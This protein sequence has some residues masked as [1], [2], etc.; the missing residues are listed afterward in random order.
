MKTIK[1]FKWRLSIPFLLMALLIVSC[2]KKEDIRE[3][4]DVKIEGVKINNELFTPVYTGNVAQIVI[5]GGRDLSKVKL[6]LLIVNGEAVNFENNETYDCRKPISVSLEGSN[7]R[8]VDVVLKIQSPPAL[9]TFIIEGMSIP[10]EDI[11]FSAR[12]LI[13]QVPETTDLTALKVSM[14]FLNGTVLDFT[15]GISIDYSTPKTFK[16]KGI[17][18]ETI[19]TYDLIVTSEQIG[20]ASVKAMTINGV[21]TDSV[22]LV[23]PSTLVP[24]VKGLTNFAKA[25]VTLEVGFGNTLDPAFTGTGLDLL[26]GTSKVKVTGSDGI[27]KE[28]SIG[29]PQLSLLPVFSK[30]YASFG[31][32]ANDLVGTAFSGTHI[33]VSNYSAVAPT[34]IG[35]NYYNL[36]GQFEGTLNKANVTIAHSLRKLASDDNGAFLVVPLGLTD[37][38]VTTYKWNNVTAVADPYIKYSKASLG[39]SYQPRSAGINISGSLSGNAII[40]IGMAQQADVFIWTVTGGVLNPVPQKLTIPYVGSYYWGIEPLPV[41]TQG[42]V[43]AVVGSSFTGILSM[44]NT[45]SELS[46]QSGLI[47][48]DCKVINRNGRL[49]LAYIAFSS[50]KGA[51]MRI[52]DITDGQADSYKNPI[53]NVLMVSTAANVNNTM[54]VD[55]AVI[56]GKLH[57]VFACTNLGMQLYKLEY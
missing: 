5:P 12:S 4:Q 3:Y 6:Q 10:K 36:S 37:A 8:Q 33:V 27:Q 24:Y 16:I 23:A 28:F 50:G 53:F 48:T 2:K 51:Y 49:Y 20:P 42:Y 25:N 45:M 29:R 14:E 9:S 52:C 22:V 18:E 7:G 40:T 46:K 44:N 30:A 19:Y 35:P 1:Y 17:D 21:A 31:Y 26:S 34:V 43:G 38:E 11:H 41:G 55:M 32:G 39:V 15:N 47:A 13:V 57:A 54:D 56:N